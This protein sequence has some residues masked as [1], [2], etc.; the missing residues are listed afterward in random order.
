MT[1]FWCVICETLKGVTP[2]ESFPQ[3]SKCP[4]VTSLL[5]RPGI[6]C[7]THSHAP[8]PSITRSVLN[9]DQRQKLVDEWKCVPVKV[10]KRKSPLNLKGEKVK[11]HQSIHSR[12]QVLR[13]VAATRTCYIVQPV[14]S[15]I[16]TCESS[17][18]ACVWTMKPQDFERSPTG[19]SHEE[20]VKST[21]KKLNLKWSNHNSQWNWSSRFSQGHW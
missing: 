2:D 8:I 19:R 6:F 10:P 4:S 15:M 11:N 7:Q 16:S 12:V 20:P 3:H 1:Y 13:S 17:S 18:H 5:K 21:R 9:F 14:P